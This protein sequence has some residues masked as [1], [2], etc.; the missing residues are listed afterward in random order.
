MARSF[1][2]LNMAMHDAASMLGDE[3]FYFNPRPSQL[4]PRIKNADRPS[5]LSRVQLGH[6]TFSPP[7][8]T[9]LSHSFLKPP[10]R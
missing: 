2:L 4:D 7:S 6:S 8:V 1:A 9:V 5:K 10:V 3:F